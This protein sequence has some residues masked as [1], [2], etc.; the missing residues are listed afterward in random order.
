MVKGK[1]KKWI[2]VKCDETPCVLL[3]NSIG[4]ANPTSCPIGEG[5]K[6]KWEECKYTKGRNDE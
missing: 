1:L 4:S 3:M 2:C 5:Y 6:C